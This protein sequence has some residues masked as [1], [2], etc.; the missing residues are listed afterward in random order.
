MECCLCKK[1]IDIQVFF[2]GNTWKEGHNAQPLKDGRCCS[3]CNSTKV[4]PARLNR[5]KE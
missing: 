5:L 3:N 1:D 4:I 2:N